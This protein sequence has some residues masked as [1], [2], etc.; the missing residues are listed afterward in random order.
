MAKGLADHLANNSDLAAQQQ[1]GDLKTVID[2][3]IQ[4]NRSQPITL[5]D[6]A[7]HLANQHHPDRRPCP[8]TLWRSIR[9]YLRQAR[10]AGAQNLLRQEQL[11]VSEIAHAMGFEDPLYFGRC[12]R[13]ETG[14]SPRTWRQSRIRPNQTPRLRRV[15]KGSVMK[16]EKPEPS[17]PIDLSAKQAQ[18]WSG[19]SD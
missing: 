16:Y 4:L 13:Q 8:R 15:S 10:I 6:L 19:R 18:H 9:S 7:D 2:L 17:L 14:V 5:S 1:Q 3:F 12:F 11:N